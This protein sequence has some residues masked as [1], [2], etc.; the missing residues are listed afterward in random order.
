MKFGC[1]VYQIAKSEKKILV[2]LWSKTQFQHT[3][4]P[5][6]YDGKQI[7]FQVILYCSLQQRKDQFDMD[8]YYK[9]IQNICR[10]L[11]E[12]KGLSS[13]YY[14]CNL[15]YS[16]ENLNSQLNVSNVKVIQSAIFVPSLCTN[17]RKLLL[18]NYFNFHSAVNYYQESE[19]QSV[20][21]LTQY[22]ALIMQ[23]KLVS[24]WHAFH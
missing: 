4:R 9:I 10:I 21:N 12:N 14:I 15:Y 1:W 11:F 23:N 18:S 24:K 19:S 13:S 6:P 17:R 7:E 3:L 8:C 2:T 16:N 20:I 22:V 5:H